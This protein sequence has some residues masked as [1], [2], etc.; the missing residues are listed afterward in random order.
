[1]AAAGLAGAALGVRGL[2]LTFTEGLEGTGLAS[3]LAAFTAGLAALLA[4]AVFFGLEAVLT[5]LALAIKVRGE[6]Q[7]LALREN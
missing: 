1:V 2:S 7:F 4:G 5:G 3:D 6:G